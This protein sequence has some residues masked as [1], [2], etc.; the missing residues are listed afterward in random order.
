MTPSEKEESKARV[1]GGASPAATL[2]RG[3]RLLDA[4][5]LVDGQRICCT[6]VTELTRILDAHKSQISRNLAVLADMG[7]VEQCEEHRGYRLTWELYRLGVRGHRRLIVTTAM[8]ALEWLAR[9]LG[10]S[11]YMVIRSGLGVYPLWSVAPNDD[12]PL[13][14][15]GQRWSLHA[16]AAG[17]A[18]LMN[19][20]RETFFEEFAD[21]SFE[22]FT[23]QT[24]TTAA[25]L[26]EKVTRAKRLGYATQVGDFDPELY[27]IAMPVVNPFERFVLAVSGRPRDITDRV[28]E[29]TD[30]LFFAAGRLRKKFALLHAQQGAEQ[31]TPGWISQLSL[32]ERRRRDE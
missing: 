22:R 1:V 27:A 18:L 3:M 5:S 21:V 15:P 16:S 24:P 11:S 8:D 23:A 26:W 12:V 31:D 14:P 19:Y 17:V 25:Q 28:V 10:L 30:T 6:R 29:V 20:D 32:M 2:R 9:Q 13:S 4:L 7:I